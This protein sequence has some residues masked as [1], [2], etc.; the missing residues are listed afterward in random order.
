MSSTKKSNR[1]TVTIN[2]S[3]LTSHKVA[4]ALVTA[5]IISLISGAAWGVHQYTQPDAV[6]SGMLVNNLSTNSVTR[7]TVSDQQG[8]NVTQY[9]QL[10]FVGQPRTHAVIVLRQ[11]NEAGK[12]NIVKTETIG[13]KD[14][15]Y[16]RYISVETDQKT[17][18]G[19]PLDFSKIE[20]TWG[21]TST[22]GPAA[23]PAQFLQQATLGLVP[24]ANLQASV[25]D[26]II[27]Q[28]EDKGAYQID[29]QKLESGK[30]GNKKV[31]IYPV[32]VNVEQYVGILKDIA[33]QSGIGNLEEL[34]PAAYKDAPPLKL[35]FSVAKF[36]RQLLRI[37]YEDGTQ[38]EDYSNYGLNSPI[39]LPAKTISVEE[40]QKQLQSVQ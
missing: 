6:F 33:K 4:S 15:D 26:K 40:L 13:T 22:E 30:I 31:W 34:D 19:A 3:W 10:S 25:R 32:Q 39:E 1:P 12:E 7:K 24:F 8:E 14:T 27:D 9:A 37:S 38:Q 5:L 11:K 18:T 29:Y 36:S 16:S 23:Q 17:T 20:G 21:K 35:K 2:L 28:L